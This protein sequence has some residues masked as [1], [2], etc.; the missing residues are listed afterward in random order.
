MIIR[1]DACRSSDPSSQPSGRSAQSSS[2][3][4]FDVR[5]VAAGRKATAMQDMPVSVV[6]VRPVFP[7]VRDGKDMRIVTVTADR[8]VEF[9]QSMLS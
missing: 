5:L 6:I 2:I 4:S 1:N 8:I 3:D 7:A 9:S